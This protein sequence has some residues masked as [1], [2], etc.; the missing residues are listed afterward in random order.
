MGYKRSMVQLYEGFVAGYQYHE[1][2]QVEHEMRKGEALR[3]VWEKENVHDPFAIAV[4]YKDSQL[5]YVPKI[6]SKEVCNILA[7]RRELAVTF[8]GLNE[9]AEPWERVAFE[10]CELR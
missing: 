5:G 2:P 4:Y 8:I 6:F 3:L 1:G 7:S 10:I 9:Y